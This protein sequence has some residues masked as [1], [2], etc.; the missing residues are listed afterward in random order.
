MGAGER[1]VDIKKD[2]LEK[3]KLDEITTDLKSSLEKVTK[4][5]HKAEED[6][7]EA[8]TAA[9]SDPMTQMTRVVSQSLARNSI[10]MSSPT[11]EAIGLAMKT[12][13]VNSEVLE[14]EK[15]DPGRTATESE[16][17]AEKKLN[18]G[19][20]ITKAI[21]DSSIPSTNPGSG[22]KQMENVFMDY[23]Y[24][25]PVN[26]AD[27][28]EWQIQTDPIGL[29]ILADVNILSIAGKEAK[30]L[31]IE[32]ICSLE[33][34]HRIPRTSEETATD[35]AVLA[36]INT[37]NI[38]VH[39]A[40]PHNVTATI[41]CVSIITVVPVTVAAP[42]PSL[43][44]S[45][46]PPTTSPSL[47]KSNKGSFISKEDLKSFDMTMMN[48]EDVCRKKSLTD[49]IYEMARKKVASAFD[50][51]KSFFVLVLFAAIMCDLDH[52]VDNTEQSVYEPDRTSQQGLALRSGPEGAG[53]LL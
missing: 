52:S 48:S 18:L 9:V 2:V 5:L 39:R 24:D 26:R 49:S 12:G 17:E 23:K 45:T 14:K 33:V 44:P 10:F 32:T 30:A 43:A 22:A 8:R 28:S 4:D 19:A 35:S 36:G 34:V 15:E 7:K 42:P 20:E 21:I 29:D 38:S 6:L 11:T 37:T 46:T 51:L 16:L 3:A 53:A 40:R 27:K 41:P 31:E 13:N 1:R 50:P 47:P 25:S